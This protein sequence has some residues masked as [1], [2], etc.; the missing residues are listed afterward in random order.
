MPR[1]YWVTTSI[2]HATE[3]LCTSG[4]GTIRE[5]GCCRLSEVDTDRK[6]NLVSN[7]RIIITFSGRK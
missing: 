1:A 4:A 3:Y 2:T 7:S 6:F 5:W